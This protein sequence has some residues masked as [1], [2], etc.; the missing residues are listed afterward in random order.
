M[1]NPA[2]LLTNQAY[3]W[4]LAYTAATLETDPTI[5]SDRIKEALEVMRAPA[6]T[7]DIGS[8][9]YH[10]IQDAKNALGTLQAERADRGV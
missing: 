1:Y 6:F 4:E 5:L 10:A 9:E 3:L 7:V 2:K 8:L